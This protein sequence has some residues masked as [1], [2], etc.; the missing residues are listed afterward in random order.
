MTTEPLVQ[1]KGSATER[2][3]QPSGPVRVT[4]STPSTTYTPDLTDF[5]SHTRLFQSRSDT[6][7]QPQSGTVIIPHASKQFSASTSYTDNQSHLSSVV[8]GMQ[9]LQ[10]LTSERQESMS[11]TL[12]QLTSMSSVVSHMQQQQEN[13]LNTFGQ[14]TSILQAMHNGPQYHN[15]NHNNTAPSQWGHIYPH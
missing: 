4:E 13:M 10:A 9:Q 12:G 3:Q 5:Y 8:S 11:N 7:A 6:A 1:L 14:L 2:S 15:V